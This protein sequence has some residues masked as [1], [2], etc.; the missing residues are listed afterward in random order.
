MRFTVA[1][2]KTIIIWY[3]GYFRSRNK[4]VGR[5]STFQDAQKKS[6]VGYEDRDLLNKIIE[7]NLKV[8]NGLIVQERDGVALER[9]E[10]SANL[11][12]HILN[13]LQQNKKDRVRIVD[14]GGGLGT[15]FRQFVHFTK[16]RP[17][18]AVIEQQAL[19][20]AG[21]EIFANE[22]LTFHAGPEG[23]KADILVLSAVIDVLKD[24]FELV[25]QLISVLSPGLIILDRTLF[26]ERKD[27]FYTIK[28]T[29]RH[30]TGGKRYPVAFFSEEKMKTYFENLG[31]EISDT[32]KTT[33]GQ[34]VNKLTVGNYLGFALEKRK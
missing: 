20:D 25:H 4:F 3:L 7:V 2:I 16:I 33:D 32:W 31:Y 14:F 5:F 10:N 24:P 11:N 30:I 28:K 1:E 27:H 19:M 13:F 22:H 15:T 17:S 34:V 8:K 18:W 23:L 29:A 26:C 9:F 21:N 6:G 12:F